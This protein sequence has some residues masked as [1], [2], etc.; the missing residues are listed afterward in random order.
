MSGAATT[1]DKVRKD[2]AKILDGFE[3]GAFVRDTRGDDD[4]AW[5][6][7]FFPYLQ[8]LTRLKEWV[9]NP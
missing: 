4:P 1:Q 2:V 9:D 5:A 8:A 3:E 6:I 7:K